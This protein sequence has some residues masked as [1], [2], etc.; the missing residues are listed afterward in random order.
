MTL[1]NTIKTNP[2]NSTEIQYLFEEI[3]ILNI[4]LIYRYYDD[5]RDLFLF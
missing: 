2:S 1:N 3:I 4:I 5:G